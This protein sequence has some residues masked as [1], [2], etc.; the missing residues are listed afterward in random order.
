MLNG[1]AAVG[2]LDDDRLKPLARGR[3]PLLFVIGYQTPLRIERS[4]RCLGPHPSTTQLKGSERFADRLSSGGAD[5]VLDLVRDHIRPLVAEQSGL[6]EHDQ[7]LWGHSHC[8]LLV[9]HTLHP[10]ADV[11]R[12]HGDEPFVV[13]G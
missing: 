11:Q 7:I 10:T 4:A 5:G 8:G 3:A 1:N 12:L 6:N 9:L 2:A 13:V